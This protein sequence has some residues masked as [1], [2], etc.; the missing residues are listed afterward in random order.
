VKKF[1]LL[2]L[3]LLCLCEAFAGTGKSTVQKPVFASQDKRDLIA[4]SASNYPNTELEVNDHAASTHNGCRQSNL[5]SVIG[6]ARQLYHSFP[7]EFGK[8]AKAR[9]RVSC[10]QYLF[11]I[12]PSHHFW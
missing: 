3:I 4:V 1:F 9:S 6:V 7:N 8:V 11:H 10:R 12:Y 2:I 5:Q